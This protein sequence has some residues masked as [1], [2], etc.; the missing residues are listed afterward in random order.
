MLKKILQT[1]QKI[2]L[3][4]NQNLTVFSHVFRTFAGRRNRL[5]KEVGT[6]NR[7]YF[8]GAAGSDD[9]FV[10]LTKKED[11]EQRL[12]REKVEETKREE[13]RQLIKNFD[14]RTDLVL[15]E[16]VIRHVIDVKKR[17]K[18]DLVSNPSQGYDLIRSSLEKLNTKR[19]K[20]MKKIQKKCQTTLKHQC[21]KM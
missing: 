12:A 18:I 3:P 16:E 20:I 15:D 19:V 4:I 9:K 1:T 2:S 10:K 14:L 17:T 21:Q 5:R 8:Y 11:E 6:K 13:H 7:E